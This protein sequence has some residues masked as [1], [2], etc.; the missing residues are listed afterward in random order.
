[1]ESITPRSHLVFVMLLSGALAS[2]PHG[3][4]F[5]GDLSKEGDSPALSRV[6]IPPELP[7]GVRTMTGFDDQI[8]LLGKCGTVARWDP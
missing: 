5:G 1:M 4:V 6:I 3:Q 8:Y 7:C 2:L